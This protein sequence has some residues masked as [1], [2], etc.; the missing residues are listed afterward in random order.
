MAKRTLKAHLYELAKRGAEAQ[1]RDLMME[2]RLLVKT[3]PHLRDSYDPDEL[4]VRF[5]MAK[6]SGRAKRISGGRPRRRTSA[7]AR[8]KIR[9]AQKKRWAAR[10]KTKQTAQK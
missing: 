9:E 10:R 4:P 7:A 3:F 5:I 6:D 8:K 1:I 2:A